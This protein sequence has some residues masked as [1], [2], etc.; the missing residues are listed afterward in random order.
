MVVAGRYLDAPALLR[1]ALHWIRDLGPR[2]PATFALLYIA[3]T[4]LFLPG[5]VLTLGAGAV[6]GLVKGAVLVTRLACAALA[7]R[8][9]AA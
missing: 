7:R 9:A 3:A 6:F 1:A 8:G 5:S 2:G 4:V